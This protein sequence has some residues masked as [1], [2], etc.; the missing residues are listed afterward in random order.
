MNAREEK[1]SPTRRPQPDIEQDPIYLERL[2]RE[3]RQDL[4]IRAV[5]WGAVAF[6]L[7]CL[8]LYLFQGSV[9]FTGSRSG[10][11]QRRESEVE[12]LLKDPAIKEGLDQFMRENPGLRIT[13]DGRIE[14]P[15]GR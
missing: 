13:E 7:L 9:S 15:I 5:Y 8:S 2:K 14:G 11:P 12:R 4:A 10:E 6:L 3:R 1:S